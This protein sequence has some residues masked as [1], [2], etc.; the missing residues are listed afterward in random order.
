MA[1]DTKESKSRVIMDWY[2]VYYD[3]LVQNVT[4]AIRK[5]D[6]SFI[7]RCDKCLL[8]NASGFLL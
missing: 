1:L 7:I 3:T 5:C 4:C 2:L 8:Q 6:S